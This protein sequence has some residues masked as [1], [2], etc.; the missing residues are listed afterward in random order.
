M[1]ASNFSYQSRKKFIQ[2]V[3]SDLRGRA[4]RRRK[5]TDLK[6]GEYV[7][8]V[9]C[10]TGKKE[11]K[12]VIATDRAEAEFKAFPGNPSNELRSMSIHSWKDRNQKGGQAE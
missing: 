7:Y 6:E 4:I 2:Q 5:W 8:Y 12:F 10:L 3:N 9:K 1:T 11:L